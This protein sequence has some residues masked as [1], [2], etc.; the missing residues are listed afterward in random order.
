M[1][2]IKW[3]IVGCFLQLSLELYEINNWGIVNAI[4]GEQDFIAAQMCISVYTV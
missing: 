4:Q 1:Y 2:N 3:C